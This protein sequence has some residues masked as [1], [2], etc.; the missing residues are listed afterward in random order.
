MKRAYEIIKDLHKNQTTYTFSQEAQ[1]KFEAYHNELRRRKLAVLDDENRCGI[2]AK[3]IGKMAGVS[4]ML[5]VLDFAV[6]EALQQT[7]ENQRKS[8]G[9][10]ER[11]FQSHPESAE[12]WH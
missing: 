12:L 5:H 4:M 3:T 10:K 1:A 7:G 9:S 11:G 8:D 6:E 2:I